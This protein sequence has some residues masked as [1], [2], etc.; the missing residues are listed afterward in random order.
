M[1]P[2]T[3]ASLAVMTHHRPRNGTDSGDDA[4]EGTVVVEAECGESGLNS[5]QGEP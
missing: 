4:A 2:L 5:I 1:P 3:V